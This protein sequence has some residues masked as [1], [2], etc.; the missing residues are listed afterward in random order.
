VTGRADVVDDV[1][2]RVRGQRRAGAAVAVQQL[3]HP[4]RQVGGE[5]LGDER[6]GQRRALARLEHDGV[7]GGQRRA[8]PLQRDG[9]RVVPRASGRRRRRAA[10]SA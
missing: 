2:V 8:E 7:A 9:H 4:G 1:D 6:P 3:Q 10:P 5:H